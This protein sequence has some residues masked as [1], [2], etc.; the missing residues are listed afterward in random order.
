MCSWESN[1]MALLEKEEQKAVVK[2]AFKEW[3][4]EK[5]AEFGKWTL[6][7]LGTALFGAILFY[8]VTHGWIK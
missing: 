1:T 5:A 2:E 6:K 3:L 4:D 7:F 8:L